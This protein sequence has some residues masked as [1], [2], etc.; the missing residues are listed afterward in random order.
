MHTVQN[1]VTP[2]LFKSQYGNVYTGNTMWNEIP[3]SGGDVYSWN[4]KST[5]IQEP[6]FFVD[7][8]LRPSLSSP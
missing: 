6:P 1:T 7:L 4:K 2:D 8:R 3:A 5:Y